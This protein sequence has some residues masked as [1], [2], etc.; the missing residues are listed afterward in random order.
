M[1][2]LQRI[3]RS[4]VIWDDGVTNGE[5][6]TGYVDTI[7]FNYL[8]IPVFVGTHTAVTSNPS[9]LKLSEADVTDISSASNISGHVGDTDFTIGATVTAISNMTGPIHTFHVNLSGRKRYIFCS[10]TPLTTCTVSAVAELSCDIM[11]TDATTEGAT[12]RSIT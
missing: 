10:V 4:V 9:A 1:N 11:P 8:S 7:G 6:A 2:P 12:T 3:K 5:T